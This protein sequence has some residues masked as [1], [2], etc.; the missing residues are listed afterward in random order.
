MLA[1]NSFALYLQLDI[2]IH[3]IK[4]LGLNV[5]LPISLYCNY[6][7]TISIQRNLPEA[8]RC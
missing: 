5:H 3:T 8:S 7:I 4:H 1:F 6:L 2:N